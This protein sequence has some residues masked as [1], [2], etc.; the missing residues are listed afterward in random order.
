MMRVDQ[1]DRESSS[2]ER[3]GGDG[4]PQAAADSPNIYAIHHSLQH[5]NRIILYFLEKIDECIPLQDQ[6]LVNGRS[7]KHATQGS[8]CLTNNLPQ[9]RL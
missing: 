3:R 5:S 9:R 2:P 6:K 8:S 4:A 1:G 7:D